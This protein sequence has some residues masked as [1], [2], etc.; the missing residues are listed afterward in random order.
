M[1]SLPSSFYRKCIEHHKEVEANPDYPDLVVKDSIP[2][3]YFGD[4]RAFLKSPLKVVTAA[5]NPSNIEFEERGKRCNRFSAPVSGLEQ[6]EEELCQY[7]KG[8]PYRWFGNFEPV[9]NGLGASYGGKMG[10]AENTALHLDMCSPIATQ[11]KWSDLSRKEKRYLMPTGREIFEE[12]IKEIKP[13]IAVMSLG[14]DHISH[15][16]EHFSGNKHWHK[17]FLEEPG[18]KEIQWKKDN[19]GVLWTNA[20]IRSVPFSDIGKKRKEAGE[21]IL[22]LWNG[23]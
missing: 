8:S 4:V 18:R 23:H 21:K 16:N 17:V 14:W 10:C 11:K 7:F 6:L 15:W 20:I 12:L 1:T 3:P 22:E 2:I 5:L 19:G 9:L 13:D